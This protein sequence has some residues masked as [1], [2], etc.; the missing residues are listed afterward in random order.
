MATAFESAAREA[1]TAFGNGDLFVEQFL[2]K[3]RH[4]EVQVMGDGSGTEGSVVHLYERDCSVQLNNQKVVE[5]APAR[6][7]HPALRER[8]TSS[9]VQLANAVGYSNAG[10]V[11][12]LVTGPLGAFDPNDA[13]SDKRVAFLEMNPR[14]QVE[15]TVTEELTGIDLVETQLRIAAAPPLLR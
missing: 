1:E 10:T 9:A 6:G 5:L 11:E 3:A 8:L 7:I 14:I 4:I 13:A 12:F 15:H 2:E